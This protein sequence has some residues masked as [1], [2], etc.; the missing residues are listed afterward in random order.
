MSSLVQI[1]AARLGRTLGTWRHASDLPPRAES[2][3]HLALSRVPWARQHRR[4]IGIADQRDN[5]WAT[6]ARHELAGTLDGAPVRICVVGEIVEHVEPHNGHAVRLVER[7]LEEAAT[8]GFD[9]A[10]IHAPGEMAFPRALQRVAT[11]DLTLR[12]TESPRRGAPMAPVRS[13]DRADIATIARIAPLGRT[14]RRLQV[15]RDAGYLDFVLARRRL[16]AGLTA[17]GARQL[18]FLVV[19]EGM[20]AAAYVV[21]TVVRDTW[22]LELCGDHD[23]TGARAGAILQALIAREPAER[24]PAITAWLPDGFV[25]PQ[26]SIVSALPAADGIWLRWLSGSSRQLAGEDVMLWRGDLP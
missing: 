16:R 4:L 11:M 22:M 21:I 17:D 9:L 25:P 7:L 26:V 6:A 10:L 3:Y 23:P 18:L 13:G 2:Q 5:L 1:D 20:Q 24:R 12:V 15:E 19:E 8:E 14:R